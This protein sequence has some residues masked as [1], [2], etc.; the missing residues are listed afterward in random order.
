MSNVA[1]YVT[2]LPPGLRLT[3]LE[4]THNPAL[5]AL[6]FALEMK[7]FGRS[8]TNEAETLGTLRS[9]ELHG[10]RG[11][12]GIWSG[13]RLEAAMLAYDGLAHERGMYLDL[14][15]HPEASRRAEITTS[16]LAAA[17]R[18]AKEFEVP[19]DS[20]VK[21]ES[22]GGDTDVE[23]ALD[24]RGYERHRVYLRMRTDFEAPLGDVPLAPGLS[25]RGMRD[26]DW[27][28]IHAV[29]TESFLDHYDAHPLPLEVF[30]KDMMRDTTDFDRWRLVFDGDQ[31]VG[32][33]IGS[34]RYA[35]FKLGYVETLGV[36]RDYRGRGIATYLLND[37]FKRDRAA[38]FTGT[39]LHCD[40]TNPTGATRLYEAVGMRRDQ[41]YNAWRTP[42]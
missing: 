25:V 34:K 27:E 17:E 11:T 24:D 15:V 2:G 1:M 19:P 3:Q 26:D 10:A 7:S 9:S 33:S 4:E 36:L 41:E 28:V 6:V 16:L 35:P 39:S 8:E 37:A 30:R 22:F 20:F 18:Y 12:A 14:F 42:I 23:S 5:T 21:V 32:L 40:A 38:G 31:C 29:T 13:E